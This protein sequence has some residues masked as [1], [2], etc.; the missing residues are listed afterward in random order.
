MRSKRIK[1][2]F[3]QRLIGRTSAREWNESTICRTWLAFR[4][5]FLGNEQSE[6][7]VKGKNFYSSSSSPRIHIFNRPLTPLFAVLSSRTDND[8]SLFLKCVLS[9]ASRL[10]SPLPRKIVLYY[11]KYSFLRIF[12]TPMSSFRVEFIS[13]FTLIPQVENRC[14]QFKSDVS[15]AISFSGRKYTA[16]VNAFN[17]SLD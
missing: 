11:T 7:S 15:G 10:S 9:V 1:T 17:N 14:T 2:R 6:Q 8:V 13:N 4:F 12:I 3:D 16:R 5:N